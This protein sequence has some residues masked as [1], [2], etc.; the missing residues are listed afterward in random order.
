[1]DAQRLSHRLDSLIA[2]LLAQRRRRLQAH[3][4]VMRVV[5]SGED[6][7]TLPTTLDCLTA[8]NQRGYL[9]VM[10]FSHSAIQASLH[11]TCLEALAQRD[12]EALCDDRDPCPTEETFSGLYLPSL[13]TNSLSKIALGIRDNR[14]CRWAFHALSL[15]SPS[16][17]R[18]MPNAGMTPPASSPALRARLAGYVATLGE[19]G[20]TIIGRPTANPAQRP[21]APGGKPLITLSDVRQHPQAR[22]CPLDAG[23]S[24]LPPHAMKFATAVLSWCRAT[25]RKYVSGKSNRGTGVDDQTCFA[26]WRK[27]ADCRPPG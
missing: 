19:Y 11:S 6:L 8:L 4:K 23:R 18:S 12:V 26:Q 2:D 13:S 17:S 7:A 14:V 24:S 22:S 10:T 25:R 21:T 20:I 3:G 27:A 15:A 9:L 1:M 5:L 16:S